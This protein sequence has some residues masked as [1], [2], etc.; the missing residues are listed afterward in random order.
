MMRGFTQKLTAVLVLMTLCVALCAS[1]LAVDSTDPLEVV[2]WDNNQQA[3]LQTI[4]DQFTEQTGIPVQVVVKSWDAYW[5]LLEAGAMGGDMPDVFWMHSN[6]AQMYMAYDMLLDLTDYIAAS[7]VVKVENYMPEIWQLY[8]YNDRY[9]AVPKDYDTI[10]LWYNKTMFDEAGLAYPDAT[11]TYEDLLEAA[12][13]LTKA[14]GSQYG[15]ALNPSNDQDTYYN[16]VYAMGGSIVTED[17]KSGYDDPNTIRAMQYVGELLACCPPNTV[18]SETGTDV[19]AKSGQVAMIT[20]GSWMVADFMQNEYM[21]EN[22]DVAILPYDSVTG[23]RA[24]ICNGLGWTASAFTDR[25]ND[26]WALIEWFGSQEMQTLQAEL[27]VTMSAYNGTSGQWVNCADGLF[28]LTPYLQIATEEK[29]GDGNNMLV[30]RPYTFNSTQW[31]TAAQQ[32]FVEAWAD[33][34]KM[35]AVCLSFAATM[36]NL[37]AQ[38][39][40]P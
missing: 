21:A 28:D 40:V 35:E 2:I 39:I 18:M 17:R 12:K 19:L 6:N 27:G 11:W 8:T 29:T 9:Y 16:F 36:N 30:L 10:A 14:D 33:P 26:C 31:Q 22:F 25:P 34:S 32:A 7:E 37:I 5:T 38:E 4:C 24:S 20:Q 13:A 15:F 1:A 23:N 3:G